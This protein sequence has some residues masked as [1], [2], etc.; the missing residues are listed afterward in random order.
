MLPQLA[1]GSS[2]E[3]ASGTTIEVLTLSPGYVG[4][5]G[6]GWRRTVASGAAVTEDYRGCDVPNVMTGQNGGG[7]GAGTSVRSY[8][9]GLSLPTGE[10]VVAFSYKALGVTTTW[11]V[12]VQTLISRPAAIRRLTHL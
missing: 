12:G 5:A 10:Q 7:W 2:G 9:V 1:L 8:P 11:S 4:A 3:L 6:F